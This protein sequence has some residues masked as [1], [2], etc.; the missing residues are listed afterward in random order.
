MLDDYNQHLKARAE[1]GIPAKPLTAEQ[2]D[3]VIH[4]LINDVSAPHPL[5]I[6]LLTHS[7]PPGVD[8]AAK[9]KAAFLFKVALQEYQ[10]N[11]L[12][13]EKANDAA[14]VDAGGL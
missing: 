5:L 10:I 12:S 8:P 14:G 2:T 7:V 3:A 9:Q 11:G 4:R 1:M 6:D 13:P